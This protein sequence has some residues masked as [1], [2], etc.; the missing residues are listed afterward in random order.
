MKIMVITKNILSET[1]DE[2][3]TEFIKSLIVPL[4]RDKTINV[5][6]AFGIFLGYTLNIDP[7][8]YSNTEFRKAVIQKLTS[9][10]DEIAKYIEKKINESKL[11]GYSFYF[12]ILPF[13]D[14][15]NDRASII[16]KLKGE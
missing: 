4:K 2:S 9:D 1:F 15:P 10:L 7:T 3:T 16:K 5:D 8:P 12:Y 11:S 14:A 6:N 13:N